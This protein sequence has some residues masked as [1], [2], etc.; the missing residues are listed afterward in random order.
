MIMMNNIFT[1]KFAPPVLNQQKRY[2][3]DSIW[4]KSKLTTIQNRICGLN[5]FNAI[6]TPL[7]PLLHNIHEADA[8]DVCHNLKTNNYSLAE[9]DDCLTFSRYMYDL[10]LNNKML[11]PYGKTCIFGAG[12]FGFPFWPALIPAKWIYEYNVLS[13]RG[14]SDRTKIINIINLHKLNQ[15]QTNTPGRAY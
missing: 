7:E 9:I 5:M 2:F 6:N 3:S 13:R 4:P 14:C 12:F 10:E 15:I 11:V 8:V 1:T